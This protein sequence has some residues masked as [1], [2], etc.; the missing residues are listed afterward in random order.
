M[1]ACSKVRDMQVFVVN[2]AKDMDR[3]EFITRQMDELGLE[4]E[5]FTAIVGKDLSLVELRQHYNSLKAKRNQCRNLTPSEIGCAL[6]HIGLYRLILE[7]QLPMALIL[8]DDT[9]LSNGI[10]DVLDRLQTYLQTEHPM[11]TLLSP[12]NKTKGASVHTLGSRH[13]IYSYKRGFFTNGYII[14][15]AGARALIKFLY[16]VGDVADCWARLQSHRVID[17]FVVT[18]PLAL[19]NRNAFGSMTKVE[20]LK[21]FNGRAWWWKCHFKVHRVFWRIL[22][23]IGAFFD[24]HFRPYAGTCKKRKFLM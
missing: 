24:R 21:Y 20:I 11:I 22:N 23:P 4:F 18:P 16:P 17:I 15:R 13:Q 3:R 19:Q 2:M 9:I 1:C 6:S 12:V 10:K 8:E 7:R 14:T 5:F